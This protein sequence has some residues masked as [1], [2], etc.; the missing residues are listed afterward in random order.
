MNTLSLVISVY[1]EEE[2]LNEFWNELRV[3]LLKLALYRSTVIFIN[4]GSKDKV[5][6]LSTELLNKIQVKL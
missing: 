4:D 1:N 3:H 5:K 2:V 6:K